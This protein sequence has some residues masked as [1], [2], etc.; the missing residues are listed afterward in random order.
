MTGHVYLVGAGPGDPGLITVRG[1]DALRR[2]EVVLYDRLVNP[3][4]LDYAP[5]E[6]VCEY[7]GKE[8]GARNI[9]RQESINERLIAW[10][11]KGKTVV[12]LKG[13]DPFVFGRGGEE[14]LALAAEGLSF[15][16]VPG[17]SS[18]IA[19]PASAGIP[20]S[21]R[22]VASA[23]AVFAGREGQ[24]SGL[25]ENNWRAAALIPTAVFLMGVERLPVI[26][27]NLIRYGRSP[28]TPVAI[29][30]QGTLPEQEVVVGTLETIVDLAKEVRP[31]ATVVVGDTVGIRER[32][33]SASTAKN[34]LL[35][36]LSRELCH[37]GDARW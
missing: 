14:A 34:D 19:A 13:G 10:A 11:R 28:K 2:A 27:E 26:V 20:V 29:V 15:T 24:K 30:S 22:G 17:V 36:E 6:A 25:E 16:V 21:H 18:A 8:L 23:F 1:A 9:N 31:P 5:R 7:V 33:A 37:A 12:R 32:L 35:R 4:L 3:E